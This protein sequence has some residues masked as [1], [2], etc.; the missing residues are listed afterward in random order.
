VTTLLV[1]AEFRCSAEGDAA[2]RE[3]LD[4]TLSEVRAVEGCLHAVVWERAA[5]RRYL[6][7]TF[8]SDRDAVRRWVENEFHRT[9][10]MPGFRRW[11]TEGSFGDFALDADHDRARKCAACGRWTP[12]RPGWSEQ[13]PSTCRSCGAALR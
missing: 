6:F 13:E 10:L 8:W 7:T 12:G 3:H 2:L 4:R 1:T 11:C 5:E 9:V